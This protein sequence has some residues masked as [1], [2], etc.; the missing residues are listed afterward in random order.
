MEL[1]ILAQIF[2]AW[3]LAS[4]TKPTKPDCA[5]LT[6]AGSN[7]AVEV[8]QAVEVPPSS[9]NI[10]SIVNEI[11][12]CWVQGTIKYSAESDKLDASGNNTLTWELFLPDPAKYNGRYLMTGD[13]GFAGTIDNTTM[14][15]Y[16][17]LGYAVA[18]TDAG[19]SG[20]ANGDGANVPFLRNPATLQAWIHNS[21]AMATPVT[22]SL[23]TKYYS[24]HPDFS[25]YWGCST[26]GAQGYALA[27]FHPELFDGIYAGSP[28]NWYS[29]LI[30]SFL[31][32]GLHTR[33]NAYMSQQVLS[34]VT[35]NVV[36]ACDELDGVRDGLVED[37]LRCAFN[38]TSLQCKPGQTSDQNEPTCLTADQTNALQKIYAGPKD[39][40][41][42]K[43]IYPGFSLGSENGLVDQEV[44]LYLN[45][46][47]PIL[48]EVVFKDSSFNVSQFNW[49]SDVDAVNQ[50]ASPFI[51]ALSS[52]LSRFQQR[53]SKIITTQ[54]WSDQYNAALWPLQHLQEIQRTMKS[55]S[56]FIE[57][58][59]VPGG[60]HCGSNPYYPHVPAVY[61]VLD[62]L[63]PWVEKGI[64]PS[65]MLS[66]GPPD[67]TNTTRKLCPWPATAK[68]VAG[69]IDD[70]KSYD[71]V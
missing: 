46:S 21:V 30:L 37:P 27:Q 18:S 50:K 6:K 22:R 38:I 52:N 57:V 71:C 7:S 26:G 47:G 35:D 54:G 34:F 8:S 66:S 9:L 40:R 28:G 24:K 58:F 2:F 43:E 31:W 65:K 61:H 1:L 19:H 20:A 39:I 23:V 51:D 36:A 49:G 42:G 13:G 69:D 32:N 64:K 29:H 63:V 45:Y 14:L 53:G 62:A 16:L 56:D 60:G 25:Y 10:S 59:M 70:W 11:S 5:A 15:P 12:L 41:T 68:F 48:R 4:P 44:A 67:G 55:Q 33:G 17:N 3:A